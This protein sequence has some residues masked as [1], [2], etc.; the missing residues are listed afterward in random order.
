MVPP[1]TLAK[2]DE[3]IVKGEAALKEADLAERAGID[4]SS[5]VTQIKD[6][7]A[8]LRQIKNTYFPNAP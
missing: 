1:E 2:I 3:A 8:K 4:V 6:G 7:L 5:Q